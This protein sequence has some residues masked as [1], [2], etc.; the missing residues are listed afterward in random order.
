VE[1]EHFSRAQTGKKELAA[2]SLCPAAISITAHF[3]SQPLAPFWILIDKNHVF[4]DTGMMRPY[5]KMPHALNT[6][7]L[8]RSKS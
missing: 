4:P 1:I 7:A 8:F 2:P 3:G 6:Q 5:I